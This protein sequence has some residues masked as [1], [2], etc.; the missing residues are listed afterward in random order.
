MNLG[1]LRRLLVSRNATL[2][3]TAEGKLRFRAPTG[4]EDEVVEAI[5]KYRAALL[6][7]LQEGRTLNGRLSAPLLSQQVGRCASCNR[8]KGPDEFGL[9]LC[10]LGRAAHGWLDGRAD[11]PV[12]TTPLHECAAHGGKGWTGK[13]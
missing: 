3:V 6:K 12:M 9:G 7:Q 1:A 11:L 8:W 5:K 4:L 13:T 10:P 2:T